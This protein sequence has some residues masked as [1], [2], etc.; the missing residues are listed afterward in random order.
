MSFEYKS[1]VP[2]AIKAV[3]AGSEASV[4]I[5]VSRISDQAK[6]L[7]SGHV[8]TGLLKGSIMWKTSKANGGLTDGS[9]LSEPVTGLSA[10]V[11][12]ATEYGVYGEFGTRFMNAFPFLR[13]AVSM[14]V[15]S[16]SYAIAI[17]KAMY[18][19]VRAKLSRI[20]GGFS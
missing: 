18:D 7:L 9:K 6:E 15:N 5:T 19:T 11:G 12:T 13:P 8:V 3:E 1:F 16:T 17:K 2:Q 14:I 10:I 20:S 4:L